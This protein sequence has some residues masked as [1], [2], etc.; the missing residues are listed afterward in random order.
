VVARLDGCSLTSAASRTGAEVIVVNADGLDPD[1]VDRLLLAN[2]FLRVLTIVEGGRDSF[3][4]QMQ[5]TRVP[6]GQVSPKRL[7]E[8]IV[9]GAQ[10]RI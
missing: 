6:L 2:P 5:P 3:L 4:V 8:T 9:A 7:L 1:D 10:P